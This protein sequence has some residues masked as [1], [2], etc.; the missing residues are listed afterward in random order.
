MMTWSDID[1]RRSLVLRELIEEARQLTAAMV[2][3][4]PPGLASLREQLAR[5]LSETFVEAL[6][7]DTIA[8]G[9]ARSITIPVSGRFTVKTIEASLAELARAWEG[10]AQVHCERGA[11]VVGEPVTTNLI[12][13]LH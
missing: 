12:I 5:V 10:I 1:T 9:A 11:V 7:R 4:V 2:E 8:D 3:A 13:T 6:F